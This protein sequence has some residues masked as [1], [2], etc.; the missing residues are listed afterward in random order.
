M[1]PP[2]ASFDLGYCTIKKLH[3]FSLSARGTK[4]HH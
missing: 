3:V 4:R 1:L 2:S